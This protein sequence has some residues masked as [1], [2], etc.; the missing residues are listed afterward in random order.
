MQE[1]FL[2]RGK[3]KDNG[4]WIQGFYRCYCLHDDVYRHTISISNDKEFG[5]VYEIDPESLGQCTGKPDKNDKLI[6][7]GDI[8]KVYTKTIKGICFVVWHNDGWYL[9][10]RFNL[11]ALSTSLYLSNG[12]PNTFNEIIGNIHDNPELLVTT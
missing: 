8:F 6:F 7:E 9:K 4:E 11:I 10:Q 5:R 3:R 1:R 2:C 12:L